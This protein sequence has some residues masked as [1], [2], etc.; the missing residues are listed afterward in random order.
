VKQELQLD[1]TGGSFKSASGKLTIQ[2]NKP[3]EKVEWF[4]APPDQIVVTDI[5]V[6]SSA[7]PSGGKWSISFKAQALPGEKISATSFP[8]VL[9]YTVDGKRIGLSVPIRLDS[10]NS[11]KGS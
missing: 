1:S 4:P 5:D 2:W 3:P 11:A 6:K 8:S 7:G 9:A 10:N